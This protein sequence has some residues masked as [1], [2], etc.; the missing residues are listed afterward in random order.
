[1]S[2]G[3]PWPLRVPAV[4]LMQ[5]E[6]GTPDLSKRTGSTGPPLSHFITFVVCEQLRF[7]KEDGG[8]SEREGRGT[9]G[10]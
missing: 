1:M 3:D 4:W 7:V 6:D 8:G 10:V 2:K 9:Q 5:G